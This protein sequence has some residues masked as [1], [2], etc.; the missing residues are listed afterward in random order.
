[1]LLI[2]FF[3]WYKSEGD[4]KRTIVYT[5]WTFA[6]FWINSPSFFVGTDGL[7]VKNTFVR[8][9]FELDRIF[10]PWYIIIGNIL[11]TI[12]GVKIGN[13]WEKIDCISEKAMKKKYDD[14]TKDAYE[15]KV[16]GRDLDYLEKEQYKE[17]TK[18]IKRMGKKAKLLCEKPSEPHLIELYHELLES[19]NQVRYYTERDGIANLKAQIK[20]DSH[21]MED[22]LFATKI[23][24]SSSNKF[25]KKRSKFEVNNLES[26][27]LLQTVSKEFDRVFAN[28]L[29][30]VVKCIALDLGGVYLDG[31]LDEFYDFL[32]QKYGIRMVRNKQDKINIDDELMLG[33]IKI[34]DFIMEK[35]I[36]KEIFSNF[37]SNAWD[38]IKE[39]WGQTWKK[40]LEFKKLFEYIGNEDI[41]IVPFSNLDEDNGDRYLREHY[42]PDCCMEH[43]F[44][45]EKGVSKPNKQAFDDFYEFVKQKYNIQFKYQ[46][47]LIDDQEEN[48]SMA[49]EVGWCSIRF[50]RSEQ[51]IIDLIDIL[52]GEGIL[53]CN[54][55]L[56]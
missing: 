37:K 53:P 45:Y 9:P 40:N 47:M 14:F 25:W 6:I 54:Y 22:G 18:R 46:I 33:R 23:D 29:N 51:N 20:V 52:K 44:S 56:Q 8:I 7:K 39:Q 28:S 15:L 1:M 35:A 2:V 4:L 32:L 12:V 16:I 19:G 50:I 24:S 3:I 13:S 41:F 10:D 30:P 17:Q 21:R 36:N 26:S 49:R 31:D 5:L 11:L 43:F 38:N 34:K 27:F 48:I 55:K 42:L